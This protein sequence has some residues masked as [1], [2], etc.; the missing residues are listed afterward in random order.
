[1]KRPKVFFADTN[2]KNKKGLPEKLKIIFKK[3]NLGNHIEQND[4]C[5][6]KTHFGEL[7]NSAFV[8]AFFL[9]TIVDEIKQLGGKPFLTDANTLYKGSRGNAVDHLQTALKHGFSYA[10][11]DAPVIIADGLNGFDYVSVKIDGKH[12]KE[13]KIGSSAF[14][15]DALIAVSHF[16]GHEMTGFGGAFKNIGMGLGARSAKQQMHSDAIPEVVVDK[17]TGCEKCVPY[18]P[19]E[20]LK[21]EAKKAIINKEL[22]YACGECTISCPHEAIE[23]NWGTDPAIMQ[24][25]VV[26][27]FLGAVKDKG[28]KL[29]YVNFLTNITP[30]CDCWHFS[31]AYICPD[32]G[33]LA[34]TDPVAI[35]KA[36]FD[37]V[38]EASKGK[39][40]NLWPNINPLNQLEYAQKLGL[41]TQKYDLIKLNL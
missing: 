24:E 28:K 18:C 15:A 37:L 26:E 16:K 32:I 13:V 35:D 8:Q 12:F 23:I 5:A 27:H 3:L 17:C 33:I 10:T 2:A 9:R 29:G 20:A 11:V 34:S 39:I 30:D 38:N 25:K 1:M 22:C 36:S 40:A 31:D 7:G 14:Y 6:V 21:T 41:G 4:L 19:T